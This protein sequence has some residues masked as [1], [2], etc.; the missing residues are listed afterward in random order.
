MSVRIRA[1]F[2]LLR[3]QFFFAWPLLFASGYLLATSL[4][5]NFSWMDLIRVIL[6]GFFGFEG[7]FVLN[8]YIDRNYDRKDIETKKLTRYWRL[9]GTRPIPAGLVSPRTARMLFIVLALVT[10][11]LI[12]TLPFPHSIV[13]LSIMIY[14]YTVEVFYQVV[15]R[16]Q[17]FP[18]AQ[19][20]GRTDFALFPVA[21]YL[22]AGSPDLPAFLYFVFFY[23]FAMAH[24]GA[25]DIIDVVNDRARGMNTVTTLY[26]FDG[27]VYWIAGF[28]ALHGVTALLFLSR[29]GWI[30][31][32]GILIGLFLLFLANVTLLRTRTS[33]T[34]LTL[35]P[36][37]HITML[38]YAGAIALDSVI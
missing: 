32:T 15:K 4:Y 23:P 36:L 28:T 38:L 13:V 10:A 17:N 31:R 9:F 18:L 11:F 33:D 26:G 3:F 24:L 37:F 14:C 2:D 7:G 12:L 22:C 34:G 35:L 25:N 1:Y 6:I 27:T 8:D 5:G 19:L 21:G 20:I 16:K 30:A 29:L